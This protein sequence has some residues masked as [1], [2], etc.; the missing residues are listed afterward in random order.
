[1]ARPFPLDGELL[2]L[3]D[4]MNRVG[5]AMLPLVYVSIGPRT[6]LVLVRIFFVSCFL[7]RFMVLLFAH[8]RGGEGTLGLR[9]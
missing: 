2:I 3:L 6:G 1:M 4:V 5:F 7:R 8:L 9:E